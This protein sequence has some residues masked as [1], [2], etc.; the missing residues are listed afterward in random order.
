MQLAHDGAT[1]QVTTGIDQAEHDRLVRLH[2]HRWRRGRPPPPRCRSPSP[3][4]RRRPRR[5]SPTPATTNQ[6]EAVTVAVLGNDIDPLGRGLTVT[7][8]GAAQAGTATTDG[9]QVTFTPNPDFFGTTSFIYRVRD[10]A[11]LATR[12]SEAQV[13]VTVI[14]QPSAPGTPSAVAGNAQATVTWA[15]PPANGAP[16]DDYEI[17]IGGGASSRSAARP[18]TRGA[19]SP[20]AKPVQ[21]SVRG[22]QQRRVGPVERP[23]ARRDP[24]HRAGPAGRPD[25]A[26]R[27]R[28]ADRVVVPA[29]QR[30][31]RDHRLRPADRR[32]RLGHPARRQRPRTFRW[33]GLSNGQEYTFMV[34]AVNAKGEGEFSSPSAPE[35]PLRAPD[36]PAAARR[37][38]R[39]QDDP[40]QLEP[41]RQRRR[42][43]HRVRGADR[44]R[45]APST[46]R[47]APRCNGPTCPTANPSSSPSAPA[48]AAA[49]ARSPPRRRRSS[50]AACPTSAGR[51]A[52]QRGDGR[53]PPSP[54]RPPTTRAAR[55][56]PTRSPPTAAGTMSVGGDVDLG[57]VR[58][59]HQR[60]HLHVHRRR[61]QRGRR[62]R[63]QRRRPTPSCRPVRRAPRTITCATPDT[64]CVTVTWT[65]RQPQRQPD[66]HLPA[67]GQRRRLGERRRRHVDTRARLANG[68]TYT[69]RCGPSTTS[70]PAPAATSVRPGRPA[71][72]ARSAA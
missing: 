45:P 22:P 36:A 72:R 12:E 23:V 51:V 30:G 60:H 26:V 41:A 27:R 32:R 24:R 16:I 15:A 48:T 29:G 53:A 37:R 44:L 17:R 34:R 9:Q 70:V 66:H 42:H 55:S 68:T 19:G 21:F 11:N 28:R 47:P 8:A 56:P 63:R 46:R 35:H 69:S 57:D 39:R 14:G 49:G 58:R 2:R 67:V 6:G 61:P 38:A 20:T 33:E 71:S 62:R 3:R 40:R 25:G 64:G 43:R 4:R 31:Q 1:V 50:R 65:G 59:A 5:P 7:S 52:A 54:G 18:G 13:T 10:G